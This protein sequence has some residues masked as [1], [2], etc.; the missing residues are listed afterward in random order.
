M[1]DD[2]GGNVSATGLLS[3]LISGGGE[4]V[5]LGAVA[6]ID[7]LLGKLHTINGLLN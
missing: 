1:I 5:C 4:F 6:P 7:L 2:S 3:V